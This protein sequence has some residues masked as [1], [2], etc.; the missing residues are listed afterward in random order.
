MRLHPHP[1]APKALSLHATLLIDK[2]KLWLVAH[3][4]NDLSPG[5]WNYH[6]RASGWGAD[7]PAC[8]LGGV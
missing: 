5:K 1:I 8:R 4:A 2:F 7:A 6:D 3:F